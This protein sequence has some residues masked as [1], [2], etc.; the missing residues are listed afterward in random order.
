VGI[1]RRQKRH[2]VSQ[3]PGPADTDQSQLASPSDPTEAVLEVEDLTFSYL[4]GG[5]R[6]LAVRK[7][8]FDVPSGTTVGLVGESGSGKSTVALSVMRLIRPPIGEIESG[9]IRLSGV[10]LLQLDKARMRDVLHNDIGY[11]PQDP[12]AALDPLCTIGRHVDETLSDEVRGPDRRREIIALLESLGVRNAADRLGSYPHE[13]SGG[14]KQRVAIATAL[15]RR[16]KLIIADEP[17]TALDVTTQLGILRLLDKLRTER[18]LSMLF[19]T[20]DLSVARMLCQR[21][22]VMYAGMVVETGPTEEVI[23]RPRHPYT[24]AL[25]GAIPRMGAA[26]RTKLRAIPGQQPPAGKVGVGC[27]F[28]PRCPLADDHCRQENPPLE[29][30][31]GDVMAA[32]W[33][34]DEVLGQTESTAT[35]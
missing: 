26:P 22:V 28:A 8:S 7:V 5:N 30:H 16:P 27:P 32:C 13:F 12:A 33:H 21:V 20:H 4:M 11:I 23:D 24:R 14:M 10:D 34:A 29:P 35:G 19:V 3:V 1:T 18:G 15:A 2:N 31:G 17:T 9:S 6:N 25:V